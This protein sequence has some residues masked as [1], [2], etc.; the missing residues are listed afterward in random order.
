MTHVKYRNDPRLV[1][2]VRSCA[3]RRLSYDEAVSEISRLGYKISTKTY[4]RI[5]TDLEKFKTERLGSISEEGHAVFT[6]DS[7]DVFKAIEDELWEI[8]RT[9]K[10]NWQKIK[11]LQIIKENR[12]VAAEFYE[13]TPIINDLLIR[14]KKNNGQQK[15]QQA[16]W[17][18]E[19]D[20]EQKEEHK[21]E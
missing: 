19:Q 10:D 14:L 4:Q 3:A 12:S 18:R 7:I 11:S 21:D 20:G 9:T 13:S 1:E 6:I 8:V 5:K 15:E 2:M 16:G 17:M